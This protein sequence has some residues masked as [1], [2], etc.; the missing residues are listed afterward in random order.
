MPTSKIEK[1]LI[2]VTKVKRKESMSDQDYYKA[3]CTKIEGIDDDDWEGLSSKAQ[4]WYNDA[5]ASI[6][7]GKK[8]KP[9][10]DVGAVDADD[11]DD[12]ADEA[13]KKKKKPAA[14]ED[15]DD[16]DDGDG[17]DDDD[18]PAPKK[19]KKKPADEDDD[20]G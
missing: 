2:A 3:I 14:D 1:E 17:D 5:V 8:I 11:D 20:E 7:K 12:D 10:P 9:F 4:D 19:K 18:E 13:P 16:A 15:D 6:N